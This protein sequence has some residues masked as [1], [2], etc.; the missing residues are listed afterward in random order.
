MQPTSF[1]D[2]YLALA[3]S[4]ADGLTP[5]G[6]LR[7][8]GESGLR[9]DGDGRLSA[10]AVE[11]RSRP[12][13]EALDLEQF[14]EL[15]GR[16]GG[17]IALNAV[18]GRLVVPDFSSFRSD[19][20]RMFCEVS[21]ADPVGADPEPPADPPRL[22]VFDHTHPAAM[23]AD[24]IPALS[25]SDD[26]WGVAIC[27]VDGQRLTLG[28]AGPAF[29][30]QSC[31]KP[32]NYCQALETFHT[33]DR[34]GGPN[35]GGRETSMEKRDRRRR[36]AEARKVNRLHE[37]EAEERG[38]GVH[39]FVGCEPSGQAFNE[40]SFD[41]G[42]MPQNTMINAGALM[43]A[44]LVSRAGPTDIE[45]E[46]V[47]RAWAALAGSPNGSAPQPD[48]KTA[49]GESRTGANNRS[50][51]YKMLA[52][53]AFPAFVQTGEH[54]ENV[55][56]FYFHCCA[57]MMN[58]EEL[59]VAAATLAN[60]GLCPATGA[61][62][63]RPATVRDAL[64]S[65]LH[66]GMYDSSGRFGRLVGLPAKSGVGG[67]IMLVVPGV[68]GVCTYSPRLDKIG[69]SLRG[70]RFIEKLLRAYGL[71]M[72]DAS[73]P[74]SSKRIDPTVSRLRPVAD[75][76]Q[77]VMSAA[78]LGDVAAFRR[79]ENVAGS[80]EAYVHLLSSAD[81]DGRTP[82]HL[83]ACEGHPEAAL[84]L[85]E[86]GAPPS[87]RDRW[88]ATPLDEA[89]RVGDAATASVLGSRGAE[90]GEPT[91]RE[92]LDA[93][94]IDHARDAFHDNERP[95]RTNAIEALELIWAAAQGDVG[96]V[97]RL[98]ADGTR[99]LVADYDDRT[100]LHLACAEARAG[101]IRFLVRYF[102]RVDERRDGGASRLGYLLNW[103]DRWGHTPIEELERRLERDPAARAEGEGCLEM[104]REAGA[105][106]FGPLAETRLQAGG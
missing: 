48:T 12:R 32:I 72:L 29:S 35:A 77:R 89:H 92:R 95:H 19:V 9:V 49:K 91:A 8:L 40:F 24:Y 69:N 46:Q 103:P 84:Y 44:A 65:M 2:A 53:E 26:R 39:D 87:P 61:R 98:A 59:S 93:R 81:Y 63:Y 85:L 45:L 60:R 17:L 27:T 14:S 37:L 6:V 3:S 86:H 55:L 22:A 75:P 99:L 50:L 1:A 5:R 34:G 16:D 31:C 62:V 101:V 105:L 43:C 30:I 10:L 74:I 15:I 102:R 78:V 90:A 33:G 70:L 80:R 52:N 104:L 66:C 23:N 47:Q 38:L 28:D 21:S 73:E 13:D 88:G 25:S 36:R 71:H 68:M 106:R 51:A 58:A 20:E 18:Q 64:A 41:A 100:P 67:A 56:D 4:G 11:L 96:H 54:V 83:T 42:R 94:T 76:V 7:V 79:F 57:L 97:R 82:L